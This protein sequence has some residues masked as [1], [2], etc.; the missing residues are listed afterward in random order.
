[1][2]TYLKGSLKNEIYFCR[3]L[4]SSFSRIR[5]RPITSEPDCFSLFVRISDR[6]AALPYSS[7]FLFLRS[8]W[9]YQTMVVLILMY[10]NI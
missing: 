2:T 8:G 9:V 4:L 10:S 7:N 1:M 3:I 6:T 5:A